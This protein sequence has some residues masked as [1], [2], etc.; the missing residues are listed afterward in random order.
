[1]PFCIVT[2]KLSEKNKKVGNA[3]NKKI[4][5]VGVNAK[6]IH[7]N[8]AIYSLRAYVDQYGDELGKMVSLVSYT[9]NQSLS[10]ILSDIFMKS[11]DVVA[12]SC[13]IWNIS[14]VHQIIVE[15]KKL[16]P[17]TDIWLG[18]PE[19]SFDAS[20]HVQEHPQIKGIMCGEGEQTFLELCEYYAGLRDLEAV[21]GIVFLQKEKCIET[22]R[23]ELTELT[24]IPFLY[25]DLDE[26]ENKIIYYES[27]R[28]CPFRCSYCLSS[29]DKT[30]RLRDLEVV[31]KEL[32]FFLDHNLSQV[33]FVDRTFNCNKKHAMEI[34]KYL[35]ENDNCITNFHFEVAADILDEEEILLLNQFRPGAV[36]LEIGVQSTNK[37]TIKEIDRVMDV[38]RLSKVVS[39]I[40]D[41]ENIHI[42]LDL[43]AGLP[44]EDYDSFANSFNEVYAMHPEQLQLGF[45]KVLKGSKMHQ[46]AT[47]YGLVYT[48][49]PPYEVLYTK[50]ISY[51]DILRLKQIEEMVEI[52]YNSNQ[53][54]YT[55]RALETCFATPFKMY[56]AFADFYD[57]N[58]YFI[59]TPARSY[60][61]HV[62]LEFVRE[63]IPEKEDYYKE[64]LTMDIYLRENAKSRPDFAKDLEEDKCFV[65]EFYQREM[66]EH[67]L[68]KGYESYDARQM[69]RMTHIESFCYDLTT[70]KKQ[71]NKKYILF[72]YH[73]R[74]P[75]TYEAKIYEL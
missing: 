19:V 31:K 60:R 17:N 24:K 32:Q 8:P 51:E 12:I 44:Y 11:P 55:L 69:A 39:K 59:Q 33:K 3:M 48:S 45:L 64:L 26:F 47:E 73:T 63:I 27:S 2:V 46:N 6:Y 10:E 74:N 1:M 40:H 22:P 56:E 50:W 16:L 4:L 41:K 20:V 54:V 72:D 18:G 75:L 36:Q 43:I 71:E 30:V 67:V 7:S 49:V 28:G 65:R 35:L 61:Y 29:I 52:Y 58:H 68:L 66:K 13:Y 9:I 34:W 23:R 25:S 21:A 53:F 5:L 62:L 38:E 15:I 42:H 57:R 37:K 70:G 14:L